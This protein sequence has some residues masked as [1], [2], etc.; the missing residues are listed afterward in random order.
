MLIPKVPLRK[1][2]LTSCSS[3]NRVSLWGQSLNYFILN[4]KAFFGEDRLTQRAS[5]LYTY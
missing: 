5:V 2:Q 4:N 3:P 1:Q